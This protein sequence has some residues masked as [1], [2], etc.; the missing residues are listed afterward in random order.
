MSSQAAARPGRVWQRVCLAALVA[1]GITALAG[2]SAAAI[3]AVPADAHRSSGTTASLLA[4]TRHTIADDIG[5]PIPFGTASGLGPSTTAAR[6]DHIVAIASTPDGRGYWLASSRG[7]VYHFGD[8][9]S[10]GSA[11]GGHSRSLIVAMVATADGGGYWLAASDGAVYGCGDAQFH[12]SAF[13]KHPRVLHRGHGCHTRRRWL[14]AC[15]FG[16]RRLPIR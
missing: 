7:V 10:H 14:L 9:E 12:G 6:H 15:G 3:R 11:F 8:A 2:G 13:G 5:E 1:V 16:R 4:D